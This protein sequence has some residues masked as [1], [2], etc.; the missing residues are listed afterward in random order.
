MKDGQIQFPQGVQSDDRIFKQP[1]IAPVFAPLVVMVIDRL[2]RNLFPSRSE[3]IPLHAGTQH[4]QDVVEN[5]VIRYFRLS[6]L[7]LRQAGLDESIKLVLTHFSRQ[8]VEAI[9]L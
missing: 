7:S 5:L 6:A 4:I 8:P 3:L 2:P 1:P 9:W